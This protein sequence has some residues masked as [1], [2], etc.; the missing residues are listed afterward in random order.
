MQANLAEV[1]RC[2]ATCKL[3]GV[4]LPCGLDADNLHLFDA[5]VGSRVL[6]RHEILYRRG[7]RL[8]SIYVVRSG[9]VEVH[10]A[11]PGG[12]EQVVGFYLP[13]E[14]VGLDGLQSGRHTTAGTALETTNVCSI[15]YARLGELCARM[16]KLNHQFTRLMSK[17]I[18]SQ[19]QLA[20]LLGQMDMEQRLATFLLDL[21]RRWGDL[22]Y[23]RTYFRLP[24]TRDQLAS[25]LGS[26][27][28]SVSRAL[29]R[30]RDAGVV[31]VDGKEF[32]LLDVPQLIELS[33]APVLFRQLASTGWQPGERHCKSA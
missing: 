5:A 20:L 21:S 10:V 29:A 13:G 6:Q 18:A 32:R 14:L 15:P 7:A 31:A 26:A 2:C 9:S 27:T 25:Y 30:L 33:G 16:P 19:H 24:M 22:G 4:C 11:A 23:S 12:T 8:T 17:E 3:S 1:R 28:E